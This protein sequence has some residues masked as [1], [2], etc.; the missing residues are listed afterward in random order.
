MWKASKVTY[1]IAFRMEDFG[2]HKYDTV[3]N[4]RHTSG[5]DS[6]YL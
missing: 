2:N 1:Y 5:F 3:E 4:W 6:H